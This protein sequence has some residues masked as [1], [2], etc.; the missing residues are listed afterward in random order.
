M[1]RSA[2]A[3]ASR[4]AAIVI[5]PSE[6]GRVGR[7]GCGFIISLAGPG[8][9]RWRGESQVFLSYFVNVNALSGIERLFSR[10]VCDGAPLGSV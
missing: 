4:K 3:R 9:M 5:I 1:P 2:C 6:I 10:R 8:G 7:K